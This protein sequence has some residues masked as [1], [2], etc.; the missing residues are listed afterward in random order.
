MAFCMNTS[1]FRLGDGSWVVSRRHIALR[2]FRTW[3]ALDFVSCVPIECMSSDFFAKYLR[4]VRILRFFKLLKVIKSPRILNA[5]A[6][7][8]DF[9]SKLQT[10]IKYILMLLFMVHWSACLLRLLTLMG[11]AGASGDGGGPHGRAAKRAGRRASPQSCTGT[12]TG[13]LRK[14]ATAFK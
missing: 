2:Y 4:L 12:V 14:V 1:Y 11:C 6:S 8:V 10:V 9:S 13:V 5:M 7:H 3:F